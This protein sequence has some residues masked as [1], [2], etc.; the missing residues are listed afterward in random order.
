MRGRRARGIVLIDFSPYADFES[1]SRAALTFLRERLG[2][3]LWM[4]TR[5]ADEDWIILQ[6]AGEAYDIHGGEVLNWADSFC[7]RMVEGRGPCIAP[8]SAEIGVFADAPI[9]RQLQIGAYVGVPLI[10]GDGQ[11][12]G[13]LCAIDPAPQSEAIAAEYPLVELVARMLSTVL[14]QELRAVDTERQLRQAEKLAETDALTGVFN[15]RGWNSALALEESRCRRY[16]SPACVICLDL[17]RLKA[18][19]DTQ[20]H[21]AGDD[22]IGL[23]GRLLRELCRT[24]DVIA[25]VGGDEFAVLCVECDGRGAGQLI[26]RLQQAFAESG[27]AATLGMAKRLPARGLVDAWERADRS[28]YNRKIRRQASGLRV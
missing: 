19:N 18:V 5:R 7:S 9:A 11:L 14:S 24:E 26:Q 1:A 15:R 22:L 21:S 20:G 12:F 25:R 6:S 17:D 3:G 13:T 2:F 10:N 4:V 16:G 28:M 8:R 23:T 27:V